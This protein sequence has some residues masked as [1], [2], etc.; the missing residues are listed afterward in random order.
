M[1][2]AL[3]TLKIWRGN[4]ERIFLRLKDSSHA[5]IDLTGMTATLTIVHEGGKHSFDAVI[6]DPPSGNVIF[7]LS[8]SD[9]RAIHPSPRDGVRYEVELQTDAEQVTIL[10]GKIIVEGGD[11]AD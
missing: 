4:T 10:A 8:V 5:V 9:T 11:N 6:E 1:A 7:P 2:P 3:K